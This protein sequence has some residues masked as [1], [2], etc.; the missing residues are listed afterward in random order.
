MGDRVIDSELIEGVL[1]TPLKII[2]VPGGNVLHSMKSSD[3]GYDG[4][5]EAYFSTIESGAI[6]AWKRHQKMTLNL[7]VPSGTVRFVLFDD[8]L[9]MASHG[10]FQEVELSKE[11]YYRLTVPPM[12]W[13]GFQ[14]IDT[15]ESLLLNI[16]NIEHQVHE[17]DRKTMKEIDFDWRFNL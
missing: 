6:K 16:A 8:R 9:G 13:M 7:V 1:I 2:D 10:C 12:I 11:H 3:P 5:G 17:V 4:Y 15:K 14:G